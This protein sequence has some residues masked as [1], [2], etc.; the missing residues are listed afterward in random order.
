MKFSVR[1]HDRVERREVR[2]MTAD[3]SGKIRRIRRAPLIPLWAL[4]L[5]ALVVAAIGS[6]P[7]LRHQSISAVTARQVSLLFD[8]RLERR[9]YL[10]LCRHPEPWPGGLFRHRRLFRRPVAQD[11]LRHRCTRHATAVAFPDFMEWNGLTELPAVH[12]AA[13][14][15][16]VRCRL[17]AG[18]SDVARLHFRGHNLQAP[19]LRRVLR[20]DHTC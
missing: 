13:D 18:D 2:E 20:G 3:A 4:I 8:L 7:Y 17:R 1:G 15:H 19:Y 5:G 16:A 14:Q 6:Y 11:Q 12:D 9:S 10:G